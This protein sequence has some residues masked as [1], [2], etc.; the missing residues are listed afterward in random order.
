MLP[1]YDTTYPEKIA[2][3]TFVRTSTLSELA[4]EQTSLAFA[5]MSTVYEPIF[6]P[7][8]LNDPGPP[9]QSFH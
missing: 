1:R 7:C 4:S 8:V 9:L 6:T 2:I 5:T 3:A